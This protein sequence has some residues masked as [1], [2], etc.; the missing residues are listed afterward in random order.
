[1]ADKVEAANKAGPGGKSPQQAVP[2]PPPAKYVST[3]VVTLN[4]VARD[5]RWFMLPRRSLVHGGDLLAIPEPFQCALEVDGGKSLVTVVGGSVVRVLDPTEA[6]PFGLEIKR[7][8]FVVRPPSASDESAQ[9]LRIGVA[10]AGDLWRLD[11]Q[12]GSVAGVQNP[13]QRAHPSWNRFSTR[14]PIWGLLRFD[15]TGRG[16]RPGRQNVPDQ[17]TGLAAV[18]CTSGS[19]REKRPRRVLRSWRP[20]WMGPQTL[21]TTA[22]NYSKLFEKRFNLDDAVE[23]SVPKVADDG[24]PRNRPV[25]RPN[26]W[27]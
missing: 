14:M 1:M 6:A 2:P 23:L 5:E 7:G 3:T 20:E 21:T 13:A 18:A 12:P 24:N 15:G 11:C 26:A 27:D 19:R 8:Q 16:D 17:R 25:W 22:Q 9:P 10:I 4:Y